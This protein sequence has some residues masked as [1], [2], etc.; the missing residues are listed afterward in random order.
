MHSPL[1]SQPLQQ[2]PHATDIWGVRLFFLGI[3]SIC[4]EVYVVVLPDRCNS[5]QGNFDLCSAVQ[6]I[7]Q[8][9]PN[10]ESLLNKHLIS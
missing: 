4:Y 1:Q 10:M 6:E 2:K 3:Q 9:S 7:G 8:F 5:F